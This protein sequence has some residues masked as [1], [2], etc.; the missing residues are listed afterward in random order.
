MW[1]KAPA[2]PYTFLGVFLAQTGANFCGFLAEMYT[3]FLKNGCSFTIIDPFEQHIPVYHM[4][5][6]SDPLPAPLEQPGYFYG[7]QSVIL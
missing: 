3:Q 2:H 4:E 7:Y 5:V 6:R 1:L